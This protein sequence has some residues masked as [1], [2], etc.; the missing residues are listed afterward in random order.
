MSATKRS[1]KLNQSGMGKSTKSINN[2]RIIDISQKDNDES[3]DEIERVT[4]HN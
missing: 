3:D 2:S 4:D 1:S